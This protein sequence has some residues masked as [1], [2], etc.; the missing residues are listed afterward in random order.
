MKRKSKEV[1]L[2]EEQKYRDVHR[3]LSLAENL[4]IISKN[5]DKCDVDMQGHYIL[6]TNYEMDDVVRKVESQHISDDEKYLI[7]HNAEGNVVF[8]H[9]KLFQVFSKCSYQYITIPLYITAGVQHWN[10]LIF[11]KKTKMVERFEPLQTSAYYEDIDKHLQQVFKQYGYGYQSSEQFCVKGPQ[12]QEG[13]EVGEETENCGYW[14]LM[15]LELKLQSHDMNQADLMQKLIKLIQQRGAHAVITEFKR[16]VL[17]YIEKNRKTIARY[18]DIVNTQFVQFRH[19]TKW[20]T[21]TTDAFNRYEFPGKMTSKMNYRYIGCI[22]KCM[23]SF[24]EEQS[25]KKYL[26]C[27]REKLQSL[28]LDKRYEIMYFSNGDVILASELPLEDV[29]AAIEMKCKQ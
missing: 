19:D 2:D 20:Y 10:L 28:N 6:Y 16:G 12:Q 22:G 8:I 15:Y 25:L 27:N 14:G 9:K 26:I 24:D 13:D 5:F 17:K 4:H 29:Y 3:N 11:D 1:H 21:T 18:E 7:T 23:T